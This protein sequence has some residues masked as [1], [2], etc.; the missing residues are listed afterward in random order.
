M[1][2]NT[3]PRKEDQ[4]RENVLEHLK[5][6]RHNHRVDPRYIRPDLL[7]REVATEVPHHRPV[8]A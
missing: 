7:K 3:L 8:Y 6:A 1:S 5:A 4:T 2:F